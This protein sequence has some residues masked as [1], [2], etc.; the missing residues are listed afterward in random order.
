LY[1]VLYF[2]KLRRA[3]YTSYRDTPR[4]G[5]LPLKERW[6][7]K[8]WRVSHYNFDSQ[9]RKGMKFPKKIK[10]HDLTLRDGEQQANLVFRKE[11]KI[12]IA[13]LLD[14]AGVDRIEA[15]MPG[16]SEEDAQAIKTIAGMGLNAKIFCLSRCMKQDVDNALRC[17]VDGVQ[18]EI[19]T[20]ETLLRNAYGWTLEKALDLTVESTS[21]AHE[22]GL[23]VT[24][25]T[26][27]STRSP[28]ST[29]WKIIN[30]VATKG[31]MDA[32]TVVDTFGVASPVAIAYLVKKLKA[33]VR[34]P[35]EIHCHN[36]FGLAVAN[37]IAAIQQGA[38]IVHTTV[39]GI[40]EGSGGAPLEEVAMATKCLYGINSNIKFEKLTPLSKLVQEC[41][42]VKMPPGKPIVGDGIFTA[43]SG[44]VAGWWDRIRD[45]HLSSLEI[46]AFTPEFVGGD[47]HKIVVGKK[48]GKPSI[49]YKLKELGLTAPED[50]L[51]D[52]LMRVKQEGIE[53]KRAL[54]DD[55]FKQIVLEVAQP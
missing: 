11:E 13:Q 9:A 50:K 37:S 20:S 3:I 38:E 28:F 43:E 51:G 53:H 16:V 26:L 49:S 47:G 10:F 52:I 48:S 22:H 7:T 39:N 15:G 29:C 42:G 12:K 36:T 33:K 54:T 1:E 18:M 8:D 45:Q 4:L 2:E 46:F 27:D 31:H 32:L 55:E 44:I 14:E 24:F 34:K 30:A 41:S 5:S 17:D 19:P 40:S 35:I 21:Y 23:H 6:N 25:F